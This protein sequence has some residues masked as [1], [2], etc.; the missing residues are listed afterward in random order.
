MKKQEI[1]RIM[2]V[3][4]TSIKASKRSRSRRAR[5]AAKQAIKLANPDEITALANAKVNPNK[6]MW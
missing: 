5:R 2:E 3:G 6:K 1:Y 4:A